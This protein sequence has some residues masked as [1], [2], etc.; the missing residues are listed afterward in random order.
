AKSPA[1]K[2]G[3]I[4]FSVMST[5]RASRG[6]PAHAMKTFLTTTGE[7]EDVLNRQ[8]AVWGQF[9][10]VLK[11]GWRDLGKSFVEALG[12]DG[13]QGLLF[14]VLSR[15]SPRLAAIFAKTA[16]EAKELADVIDEIETNMAINITKRAETELE[17]NRL[18]N[19]A[20]K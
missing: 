15:F 17:Y 12:E 6:A 11:A 3:T 18:L 9:F 4:T 8:K 14:V 1:R 2:A 20:E 19:E 7:G 16:Q 10:N 13:L 5:V